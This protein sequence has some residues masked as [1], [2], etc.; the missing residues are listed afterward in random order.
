M[1]A[2]QPALAAFA[3][4]VSEPPASADEKVDVVGVAVRL[5]LDLELPELDEAH[6]Q[7]ARLRPRYRLA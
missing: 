2:S 5:V 4:A 3:I 6:E 7:S 1:F